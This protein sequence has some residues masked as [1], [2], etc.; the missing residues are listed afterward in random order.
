LGGEI[1]RLS[2]AGSVS[3]IAAVS[4]TQAVAE[5][6]PHSPGAPTAEPTPG[7][8]RH[9]PVVVGT[10]LCVVSAVGYTATN[11]AL[12]QL[13]THV[14]PYWV[15]CVKAMPTVAVALVMMAGRVWRGLSIGLSPRAFWA[16]VAVGVFAQLCG[17][18]GFQWALEIV[19][20]AL[21]VPITH[22][23]M[24]IG[25][26]VAGRIWLGE[27]VT[28]QA[29]VAMVVLM[30][31]I[32]VLSTGAGAANASI[33]L[34]EVAQRP[35]WLVAQGVGVTCL[36]GIAYAA[37]GVVIR[38]VSRGQ[39]AISSMLLV[40]CMTGVV[41]LGAA[42]LASIGWQGIAETSAAD[43]GMMALAGMLNAAAFFA[44]SKALRLVTVMHVNLVNA[45]QVAMAAV[46]GVAFF[47]EAWTTALSIGVCLT[48]LGLLVMRRR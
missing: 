23:T 4:T 6:I 22:G 42:T 39:F 1:V 40:V 20:L 19:G 7:G 2:S 45:S 34:A 15:S 8:V 26:A 35:A 16:L 28:P 33:V 24:M 41:S 46:A 30:A 10:L 38:R 14:D 17:N 21:A 37:L 11:I 13:S 47:R 18:V 32:A 31:A 43:W 48:V 5:E 12:R 25:G 9:D 36:A 44:L 27:P 29:A 3:R